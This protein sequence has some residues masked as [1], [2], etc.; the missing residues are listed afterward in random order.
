MQAW[1][2]ATGS[3]LARCAFALTSLDLCGCAIGAAGA[4]HLARP[5]ASA[6]ALTRLDLAQNAISGAAAWAALGRAL[7]MLSALQSLDLSRNVLSPHDALTAAHAVQPLTALRTLAVR[8]A[9]LQLEAACK[10]AIAFPRLA[11]LEVLALDGNDLAWYGRCTADVGSEKTGALAR[12]LAQMPR[13]QVRAHTMHNC[14]RCIIVGVLIV[15]SL[16]QHS[17]GRLWVVILLAFFF[18]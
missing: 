16:I 11:C 9:G 15:K 18:C 8:A 13:L 3:A 12:A 5:L 17:A 4:Q 6:T 2:A 14:L 1:L 10:L 7:P